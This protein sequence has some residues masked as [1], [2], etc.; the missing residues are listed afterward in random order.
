M[1]NKKIL[2]LIVLITISGIPVLNGCGSLNTTKAGTSEYLSVK[3]GSSPTT[4]VSSS[5]ESVI[6]SVISD[7]SSTSDSTESVAI[8]KTDSDKTS[9]VKAD[10]PEDKSSDTVSETNKKITS[11]KITPAPTKE[12]EKTATTENQNSEQTV[13]ETTVTQPIEPV[14]E[15]VT[16]ANRIMEDNP[17]YTQDDLIAALE[18]EGFSNDE[19]QYASENC[20]YMWVNVWD[21]SVTTV[22][23]E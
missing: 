20:D 6:R 13:P 4:T 7:T 19:A 15:S 8:K 23:N 22:S 9:A 1:V 2:S 5:E 21:G 14:S 18:S 3:T 12:P 16:A 10:S 17:S 11:E